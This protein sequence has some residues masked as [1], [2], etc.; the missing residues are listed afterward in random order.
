MLAGMASRVNRLCALAPLLAVVAFSHPVQ[1]QASGEGGD[2]LGAPRQPAPGQAG[3]SQRAVDEGSASEDGDVPATEGEAPEAAPGSGSEPEPG[4]SDDALAPPPPPPTPAGSPVI[5]QGYGGSPAPG[6]AGAFGQPMVLMAPQVEPLSFA[7]DPTERLEELHR[8]ARIGGLLLP[9]AA[10]LLLTGAAIAGANCDS[11]GGTN[12]A[13][14]AGTSI[15]VVGLAGWGA[16]SLTLAITANRARKTLRRA[17]YRVSGWAGI[18]GI[19]L[20]VIPYTFPLGWIF[21]WIQLGANRRALARAEHSGAPRAPA[22][23]LTP[24]PAT[25][26]TAAAHDVAPLRRY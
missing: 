15:A 24:I 5:P 26:T 23:T 18:M 2:A 22:P 21:S 6:G 8:R 20:S 16:A 14:Q 4:S 1:G 25:G 10:A 3:G 11:I 13:C 9:V 12:G 7:F 17:G 19:V